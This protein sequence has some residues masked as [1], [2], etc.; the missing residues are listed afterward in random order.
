MSLRRFF[1]G[2]TKD[3][4]GGRRRRSSLE[5]PLSRC[6]RSANTQRRDSPRYQQSPSALRLLPQS[7]ERSPLPAA[8]VVLIG[9]ATFVEVAADPTDKLPSTRRTG[10]RLWTTQS[11][12]LARLVRLSDT[13][14]IIPTC[15]VCSSSC[16]HVLPHS[17]TLGLAVR[18][19]G[20]S[21]PQRLAGACAALRP[22]PD[23]RS[24]LAEALAV[25]RGRRSFK[26]H[27]AHTLYTVTV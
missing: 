1:S 18:Q 19:R 22:G 11:N 23:C 5:R 15:W 14:G 10:S 24:A 21:V 27:S 25:A 16:V 9:F 12:P 7:C 2:S 20:G 4:L 26:G 8:L 6:W 17:S 13:N 3:K